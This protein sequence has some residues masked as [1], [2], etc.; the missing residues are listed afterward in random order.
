M[1]I[2]FLAINNIET[3]LQENVGEK[4]E[5]NKF[6]KKITIINLS[7][8]REPKKEYMTQCWNAII[9]KKLFF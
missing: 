2:T 9:T 5:F 4:K 7:A 6:N 1:A 3:G 8:H